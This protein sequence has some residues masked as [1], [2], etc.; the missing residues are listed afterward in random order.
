[1]SGKCHLKLGHMKKQCN[2]SPCKS[3]YS[4]QNI[5]KHTGDK[6]KIFTLQRE[7]AEL[8]GNLTTAQNE[9]QNA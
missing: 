5:S 3:E 9:I 4:C 6:I 1:M 2:Y 7:I 8:K